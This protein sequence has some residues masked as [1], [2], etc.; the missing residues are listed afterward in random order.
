MHNVPRV[1]NLDTVSI[2]KDQERL[3][4]RELKHARF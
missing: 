1:G 2:L 3:A 4:N